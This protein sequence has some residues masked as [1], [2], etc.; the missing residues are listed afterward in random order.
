LSWKT[1]SS[2]VDEVLEDQP[3][4]RHQEAHLLEAGPDLAGVKGEVSEDLWVGL[5]GDPGPRLALG[6]GAHHLEGLGDLP[7]AEG[8]AVVLAV[9]EDLHHRPLGEG[10]DHAGPHAVEAARDLVGP[11]L[12]LAPR[13]QGGVD[14]LHGGLPL[15]GHQV[16][17]DAAAVVLHGEGAVWV[18][19]G[20]DLRGVARQGLVHGVVQDLLEEV[21]VALHPRAADV[22][23]GAVAHPFQ[24]LQNLDGGCVVAHPFSIPHPTFRRICPWGREKALPGLG[25]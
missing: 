22:H 21:V 24:P 10:V 17:G 1:S 20:G 16:H 15:L 3:K 13:V 12:K 8:D 19:G 18:Q 23:G 25:V 9:A 4:P 5:E 6:G 11:A 14:D 2:A 7:P